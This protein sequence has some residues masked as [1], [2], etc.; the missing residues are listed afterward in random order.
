MI[1]IEKIILFTIVCGLF[2]YCSPKGNRDSYL[3]ENGSIK[4]QKQILVFD[5]LCVLDSLLCI[6]YAELTFDEEKDYSILDYSREHKEYLQGKIQLTEENV[7][8]LLLGNKEMVEITNYWDEVVVDTITA[9]EYLEERDFYLTNIVHSNKKWTA[10]II[11]TIESSTSDKYLVT[12]DQKQTL[13][14]KY[15]IAF[16]GRFG[17][18]TGESYE[19]TDEDGNILYSYERKPWYTGSESCINKDLT[20]GINYSIGGFVANLFIDNKGNI[21]KTK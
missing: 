7:R 16:W 20:I 14:S 1:F 3:L 9:E 15:R 11:E 21:V 18:Y 12:I 2:S 10:I 17:T 4:E 8:K 19:I 5:T 6:D 13:I